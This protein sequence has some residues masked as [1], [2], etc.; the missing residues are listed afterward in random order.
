MFDTRTEAL[1]RLNALEP[2][3][4]YEITYKI[5]ERRTGRRAAVTIAGRP[6]ALI[7]QVQVVYDDGWAF[8]EKLELTRRNT[9]PRLAL[10]A[11]RT[12]FGY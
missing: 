11:N 10:G 6:A 5:E 12:R 3:Q 9:T 7:E 2:S 1:G 8:A 4:Y